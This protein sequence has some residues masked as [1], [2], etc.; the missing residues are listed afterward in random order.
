MYGRIVIRWRQADVWGSACS[1][2]STQ[3]W[4]E[5]A[6]L[7]WKTELS[8]ARDIN[9]VVEKSPSILSQQKDAT[10]RN[11][12]PSRPEFGAQDDSWCMCVWVAIPGGEWLISSWNWS[13]GIHFRQQ[14]GSLAP[15]C[16]SRLS[17]VDSL[18]GSWDWHDHFGV[19]IS[20]VI[21]KWGDKQQRGVFKL[22]LC[23]F[24]HDRGMQSAGVCDRHIY[25]CK[26]I[27]STCLHIHTAQQF[28]FK[29]DPK[30]YA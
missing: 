28:A 12:A 26:R 2:G 7:H 6:V 15:T 27:H 23:I 1:N 18:L 9:G 29:Q 4:S 22:S 17:I 3:Y 8:T 16:F 10:R 5:H 21:P 13:C 19:V 24:I 25:I 20:E 30:R 14:N 11:N